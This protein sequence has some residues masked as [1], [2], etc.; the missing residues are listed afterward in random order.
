MTATS[1]PVS[2]ATRASSARTSRAST[3]ASPNVN[4]KKRVGKK[5]SVERPSVDSEASGPKPYSF[6]VL[7][8]GDGSLYAGIATDVAARFEKHAAGKG[9]R[10]TRGRGPLRLRVSVEV[11]DKGLALRVEL[12]FKRLSRAEKVRIS[13][14]KAR[15]F[16]LVAKVA[17]VQSKVG[18]SSGT[19]GARPTRTRS[20]VG[21][22][23]VTAPE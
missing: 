3:S 5:P 9:A 10:Y 1:R 20:H 2:K 21:L 7:R 19:K 23:D 16:E 22:S 4:A 11:G 13:A 12:A 18:R 14:Q 17:V 6:Y 8:C 15:L